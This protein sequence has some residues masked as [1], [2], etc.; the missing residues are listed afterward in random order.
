MRE[1][2]TLSRGDIDG[3]TD[4]AYSS[5]PSFKD[6]SPE[7][8]AAYKANLLDIIENDPDVTVFGLFDDGVIIAVMRVFLFRMN[9]FGRMITASGLGY[10]GVH[11]LH[12]KKRAAQ[13][14]VDH[15]ER[16][17][18]ENGARIGL[19]LPFRPDYYK[20][21]GYGFGSKWHQYRVPTECVPAFA[22]EGRLEYLGREDLPLLYD[23]HERIVKK[24]HGMLM[25]I[26]DEKK[27]Y[28]NN[29]RLKIVASFAPDGRVDGYLAFEF[30][31]GR[32]GNY[33]INHMLVR[34]ME[35]EDNRVLGL[36]LGFIRRQQD[37]AQL[38]EFGTG[39]EF[40]HYLFDNPLDDS[41]NYA[42]F[43]NLQTNTQFIGVMYKVFEAERF[44]AEQRHRFGP[45][46]LR[47]RIEVVDRVGREAR[48][49]EDFTLALHGES[50]PSTAPLVSIR[51]DR[52]DFSSLMMGCV[53]PDGLHKMGRLAVDDPR[54]LADLD[55]AFYCAAKPICNTDF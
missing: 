47:V 22:G 15:Y 4:I 52:A 32:A 41:Q 5:Y 11:L 8:V 29:E 3:Y 25:K 44:A 54:F 14:L 48:V 20:K 50:D 12:K 6:L 30:A 49:G 28:Q 39:E 7:G 16:F 13:D 17:S 38:V 40:F 43:G 46:P 10:L 26:L 2:R 55:R 24:T 36:L 53:T 19:L 9:Y 23:C 51:L 31:N 1:V 34:E 35:F 21:S 33:T 42:A 45:A 37:Q 27:N 18:V